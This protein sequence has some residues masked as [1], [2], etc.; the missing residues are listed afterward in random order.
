MERLREW[1]LST[2]QFDILAHVGAVEGITQQ[3]LA[4][5]RLTTKGNLSQLLERMEADG[6]VCR[7][8]EGHAKHIYLTDAGRRVFAGVVPAHEALIDAQFRALPPSEQS[9]L[10]RLLRT[11][12]RTL[13]PG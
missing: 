6:L 3:E 2:A 5:V 10:L 8:R 4:E 11:L 7:V 12:D 13:A 9:Q 1:N